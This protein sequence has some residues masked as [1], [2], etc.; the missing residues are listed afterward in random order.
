M[1]RKRN[2]FEVS[3]DKFEVKR[4]SGKFEVNND[5]FELGERV[6]NVK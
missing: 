5:N 3:S 6:T 2:K 1:K 4:R